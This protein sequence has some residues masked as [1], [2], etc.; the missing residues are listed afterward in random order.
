MAFLMKGVVFCIPLHPGY[1]SPIGGVAVNNREGRTSR[2]PDMKH[3]QFQLVVKE[4]AI[5]H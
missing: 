4:I 2:S 3:V 1:C 5:A